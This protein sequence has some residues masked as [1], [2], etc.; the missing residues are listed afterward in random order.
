MT[1]LFTKNDW[2]NNILFG[3]TSDAWKGIKMSSNEGK[4]GEIFKK[5]SRKSGTY[6]IE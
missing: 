6:K 4:E 2:L 5:S 3:M 1:K